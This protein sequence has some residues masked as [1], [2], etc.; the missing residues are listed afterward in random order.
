MEYDKPTK[1]KEEWMVPK[2]KSPKK[3]HRKTKR[4]EKTRRRGKTRM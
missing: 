3:T 4:Q 1:E 2:P